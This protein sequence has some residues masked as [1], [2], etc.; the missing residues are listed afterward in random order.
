MASGGGGGDSV[1][2]T[3]H[4]V[5]LLELTGKGIVTFVALLEGAVGGFVTFIALLDLT[6]EG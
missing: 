4:F 6:E 1:L 2:D 5:A 3:L